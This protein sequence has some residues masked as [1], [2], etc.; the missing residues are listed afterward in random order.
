[1]CCSI[2][3]VKHCLLKLN[4]CVKSVRI[5]SYSGSNVEKC[6]PE[7][8]RIRTLFTLRISSEKHFDTRV[9]PFSMK[10]KF[11]KKLTFLTP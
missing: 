4:H 10:A 7:Q 2:Y 5:W 1:M 9:H 11:P 8:H 3:Y 6:G